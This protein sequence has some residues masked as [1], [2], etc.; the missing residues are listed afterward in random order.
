MISLRDC[1]TRCQCELI[2][3]DLMSLHLLPCILNRALASIILDWRH[4]HQTEGGKR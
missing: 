1:I 2:P 3:Y 4:V